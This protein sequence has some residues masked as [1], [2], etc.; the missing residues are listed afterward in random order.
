MGEIIKFLLWFVGN[1]PNWL[2]ANGRD[3]IAHITEEHGGEG[4]HAQRFCTRTE[5][6]RLLHSCDV[7]PVLLLG[8]VTPHG[9]M[10]YAMGH[11]HIWGGQGYLSKSAY[12]TIRAA[13]FRDLS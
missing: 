9:V 11:H 12:G 7:S 13:I 6:F 5:F 1:K 3:R 2:T 8:E 10:E 4:V